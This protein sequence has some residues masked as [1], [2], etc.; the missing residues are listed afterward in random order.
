M[1]WDFHDEKTSQLQ[2]LT[3]SKRRKSDKQ[4][5]QAALLTSSSLTHG[6]DELRRKRKNK[7]HKKKKTHKREQECERNRDANAKQLT[8]SADGVVIVCKACSTALW[9][10]GKR[11]TSKRA[12][13]SATGIWSCRKQKKKRPLWGL[14]CAR[15]DLGLSEG[16]SPCLPGATQ[17][18]PL[19]TDSMRNMMYCNSHFMYKKP[20]QKTNKKHYRDEMIRGGSI[21]IFWWQMLIS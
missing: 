10:L 17:V 7:K 1:L 14:R 2:A 6:L 4:T 11:L 19:C 21:R 12:C 20:K 8:D 5:I 18:K 3:R 16:A 15:L 9:Q 13:A